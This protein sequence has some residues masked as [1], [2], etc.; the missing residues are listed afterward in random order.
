MNQQREVIYGQR[1]K[2]LLEDDLSQNVKD[3]IL[4]TVK[5]TV[6]IYAPKEV[7]PEDWNMAALIA[8]AEEFYAPA[9]ELK[10]EELARFSRDELAEHLEKTALEHY[11]AREAEI[12][13]DILRDLEKIV[14]LRVVDDKW[15]DHLDA[16]DMLREG[17]GL[18][19]YGQKDPLVEYKVEAYDM[20]QAMTEAIQDDIVRYMYRVNVIAQPKVSDHLKHAQEVYAGDGEPSKKTPVQ[21]KEDVGRN[22]LCP[23]GSGKKYKQCCGKNL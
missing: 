13:T 2:I 14:M 22:Q 23:C 16:M 4:R 12:G 11:S 15:M 5:N 9:G 19:A 1:R 6:D 21:K 10:D 3:M 8:N 20:F 18:R 17:I 7:Y